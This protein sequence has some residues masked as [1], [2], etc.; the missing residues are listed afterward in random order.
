MSN[1]SYVYVLVSR[2]NDIYYEQTLLS[3]ISLRNHMPNANIVLL[4]DKETEATLVGTRSEIRKIVSSVVSIEVSGFSNLQ[5][6]RYLKTSIPKFIL[7]DFLYIDSDTIITSSLKK[8]ESC[9]FEIGAILDRHSIFSMSTAK[10]VIT[11][12]AKKMGYVPAYDDKHFNGGVMLFR[13]NSRTLDFFANWHNFWLENTKRGFSLDQIS[14][15]QANYLSNGIIRELPGIWNCQVESGAKFL[16]DAKILHF[17]SS[18]QGENRPHLLMRKTFFEK[19][20]TNGVTDDVMDVVRTPLA[21][22]SD[23]TQIIA[24][25]SV[26]FYNSALVRCIYKLSINRKIRPLFNLV[27]SFMKNM[28]LHSMKCK[29]YKKKSK[30]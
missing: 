29:I 11:Y 9:E 18:V 3:A 17:F 20:K 15:A 2:S 28:Q 26:E 19:I 5:K 1:F 12:N 21:F 13:R 16:N 14:L 10:N 25:D 27:N 7:G 22:F 6:S 24:E 4:V 23:K 30:G 8:I